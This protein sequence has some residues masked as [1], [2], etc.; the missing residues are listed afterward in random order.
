MI[1]ARKPI[2]SLRKGAEDRMLRKPSVWS[3]VLISLVAVFFISTGCAKKQMVKGEQVAKPAVEVKKEE[4]TPEPAKE[5]EK[6]KGEISQPSEAASVEKPKEEAKI[7]LKEETLAEA[8]REQKPVFFDLAGLRIQFAFDDYNLSS[9]A[10]ENL[11]KIASWMS[12]NP[13]TRIQI[14]G[15]TCEIGTNE[16]NIALGERRASSAQRYLEG[17]GVKSGRISTISYGQERPLDPG[18]T[19]EARSK[20]R[21]DEFVE[22]K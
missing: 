7:E 2:T 17:L 11:E 22:T 15:H 6:P 1:W 5:V 21:R 14:Q 16:Y 8:K 18:H 9:Q 4:P 13:A 10:K 20:N 3:V 12:Q 19:E